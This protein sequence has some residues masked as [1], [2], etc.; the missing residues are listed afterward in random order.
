MQNEHESSYQRMGG[1]MNEYLAVVA[2]CDI[3]SHNAYSL[4][5]AGR[6]GKGYTGVRVNWHCVEGRQVSF[7]C[8]FIRTYFEQ[9][10][11]ALEN[12]YLTQNAAK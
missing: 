6:D 12:E 2:L 9:L 5:Y 4:P 10:L 8:A 3:I 11:L 1:V 7:G